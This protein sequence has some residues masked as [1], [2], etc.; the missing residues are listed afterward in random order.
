MWAGFL[1]GAIHPRG[2]GVSQDTA[3]YEVQGVGTQRGRSTGQ[4]AH[5]VWVP[6]AALLFPRWALALTSLPVTW[7]DDGACRAGLLLRP[8]N[9]ITHGGM[10]PGPLQ[11]LHRYY[12]EAPVPDE[13]KA[14]REVRE[15]DTVLLGG[16]GS[17]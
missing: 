16:R 3:G 4:R 12:P 11:L 6:A 9:D 17:A 7:R 13:D 10:E 1:L 2:C 8:L 5:R 15:Q 14:E